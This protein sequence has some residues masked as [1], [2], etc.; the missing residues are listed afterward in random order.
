MLLLT[1]F[2]A[3]AVLCLIGYAV[4]LNKEGD[5][6]RAARDR[7][8]ELRD[9]REA[10]NNQAQAEA[11]ARAL[12]R[13]EELALLEKETSERVEGSQE[14]IRRLAA[15]VAENSRAQL[16]EQERL[17]KQL[18]AEQREAQEAA[19]AAQRAAIEAIE[20]RQGET[21]PSGPAGESGPPGP[22]GPPGPEGPPGPAADEP[23]LIESLLQGT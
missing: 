18:A 21:G 3:V 19:A 22:A 20:L 10:A 17:L 12:A 9:R 6:A 16:A 5:E 15:S 13:L 8:E 2:V 23:N 11:I 4:H 14:E 7:R 1:A